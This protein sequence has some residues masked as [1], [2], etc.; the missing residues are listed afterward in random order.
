MK[1]AI[2]GMDGSG[3]TTIS[4]VVADKLNYDYVEKPLK[5]IFNCNDEEF[6]NI[7]NKIYSLNDENIKS[8]FFGL[9]NLIAL[10]KD[11][12]IIDKHILGTYFWNK[13][14]NNE[15]I[16]N[17]LVELGIIPDLTVIIYASKESR[18]RHI[19]IRDKFDKDLKDEKKLL[20]GY[21]KM[22]EFSIKYKIP[23]IIINSDKYELKEIIDYIV[24]I[25]KYYESD[26]IEKIN[27]YKNKFTDDEG[28]SL[29]SNL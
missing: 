14:D 23:F 3:K 9:G 8:L 12:V 6:E 4:K 26:N 2:E 7:C 20:F 24:K 19:K 17:L 11:N 1:V 29:R 22:I 10:K 25:I 5:N 13:T 28:G 27:Y 16:F 21:D 15:N 18:I